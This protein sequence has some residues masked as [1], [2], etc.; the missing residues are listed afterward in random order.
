MESKMGNPIY[1]VLQLIQE[2]QIKSKTVM[3]WSSRKKKEGFFVPFI[4]SEGY[5]FSICILSQCIVCIHTFTYQK[6]LLH[7]LFCL[8]LKLSK[9]FSVSLSDWNETLTYN[10]IVCKRYSQS[11]TQLTI[12]LNAC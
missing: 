7:T 12:F 6:T 2:S 3:S 9:T 1:I 11:L 5:F 10:L 8:F 4:L